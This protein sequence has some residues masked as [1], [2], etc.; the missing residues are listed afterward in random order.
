MEENAEGSGTMPAMELCFELDRR[1]LSLTEIEA[2]APGYAFAVKPGSPS[3]VDVRVNG[4]LLAHGR[5]VDMGG[6][7]GVEITET[8]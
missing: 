4:T 7:I 6:K 8:L 1:H 2:L 5:L 3:P